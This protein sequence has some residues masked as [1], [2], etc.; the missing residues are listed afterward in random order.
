MAEHADMCKDHLR[1]KDEENAKL[2]T[3]STG[4]ISIIG[5][6]NKTK[7]EIQQIEK[8]KEISMGPY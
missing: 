1:F 5:K 8:L 2:H 6:K 3:L 4:K 7:T